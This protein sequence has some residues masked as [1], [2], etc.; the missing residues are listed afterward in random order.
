MQAAPQRFPGNY[1]ELANPLCTPRPCKAMELWQGLSTCWSAFVQA[2]I[3]M[4]VGICGWALLQAMLDA[5][6]TLLLLLPL[7]L[8]HVLPTVHSRPKAVSAWVGWPRR[9]CNTGGFWWWGGLLQATGHSGG[10][11]PLRHPPCQHVL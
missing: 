11:G 3:G 5:V 1:Q 6:A 10:S 4:I 8:L 2:L 7:R 9:Q